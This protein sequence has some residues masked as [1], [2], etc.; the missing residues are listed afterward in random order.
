MK[1]LAVL[2]IIVAFVEFANAEIYCSHGSTVSVVATPA[3]DLESRIVGRLRSYLANV[4]RSEIQ[5]TESLAAVPSGR[6]ALILTHQEHL[7]SHV[8]R[9]REHAE[10]YVLVSDVESGHPV[11]WVAGA[12]N[13]G[14]KRAVQRLILET[15]QLPEGLLIPD[16]NLDESPWIAK[17]EWALCPWVPE[18]VRG[19]F[20][21][22][23]ADKRL[24]IWLYTDEQLSRY[25]EMFDWFGFSGCQLMESSYGYSVFGSPEA[26]QQRLKKVAEHARE[27]GQEISLWVWAAQFDGF[28]WRD[29]LVSYEPQ[30][31][32]TAF[33]DPRVR[34]SFEKYYSHY[35][36]LAPFVDRVIGHF[37]D[38][39]ELKDQSDVFRYMRLLESKFKSENP[40]IEMGI[41]SWAQGPEYLSALVENGFDDYLL[42][43]ISMPH[44]LTNSTREQ[45]HREAQRLG[46]RLG[47]WG[48]YTT[49]YETDQLASMYVNAQ[50]LKRFYTEVRDTAYKIHPL[51]YWSEMEA[52]HL[53]NIY[54]MYAAAQLLWNPDRNPDEILGELACA[55][56]GPRI[57]PKVLEALLLIQDLRSGP[58]WDTYWWTLPNHRLGTEDPREDLQRTDSVLDAL[59]HLNIDESYVPKIPL[60]FPP[61]TFVNL[62]IPHLHQIK[63]FAQF[64]IELE[65]IEELANNSAPPEQMTKAL[66]EA[67]KPVPE[68]ATWVG[69]FGQPEARMQEQLVRELCSR[70][71]ID[72]SLPLWELYQSTDRLL[73]KI[74]NMQRYQEDRWSF[75]PDQINEFYW[76]KEKLEACV[77]KLISD[78]LVKKSG[79]DSYY[80]SHWYL[81]SSR[82][83]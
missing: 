73:Q 64:R 71:K 41:D 40:R 56:W 62:M 5:L 47:V 18:Y 6:P 9:P 19:A 61:E 24:N 30:A 67:W 68:L 17:R 72:V 21:N 48:W 76:S 11:I 42:L 10:S 50:V 69:T 55:V 51:S 7:P 49:E 65:E 52:H 36:D 83:Y 81:F 13:R 16:L 46:L 80:L 29:P 37:Y 8:V 57:G 26:S 14:L 38:P 3:S 20:V 58:S 79:E 39:G 33:D 75:R 25:V 74:Q 63:A 66:E 23:H 15:E 32:K 28:G 59:S 70:W 12:T 45:L 78:G 82:S 77:G 34:R 1:R 22:P 53:N 35:V 44:L 27:N 54:S 4:L 31:G 43:E 2:L 60:P